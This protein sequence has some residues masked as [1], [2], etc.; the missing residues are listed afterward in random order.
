MPLGS[1]AAFISTVLDP[2]RGEA[3][4]QTEPQAHQQK[5]SD[6]PPSPTQT[7]P[8]AVKR[9]GAMG[10]DNDAGG[11]TAPPAGAPG[12]AG[13]SKVLKLFLL[14]ILCLQ[15]SVYTMHRR[16][17]CVKRCDFPSRWWQR[18]L[19]AG[20]VGTRFN[21]FYESAEDH[22]ILCQRVNV[23]FGRR[24]GAGAARGATPRALFCSQADSQKP[25]LA[26]ILTR[27]QGIG[28]KCA[29]DDSPS[30]A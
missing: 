13:V 27:S 16:Y 25:L 17:R 3:Y 12:N 11:K 19:R 18:Q 20:G 24:W 15:N 8:A 22:M 4:G 21:F 28:K 6:P 9:A 30:P 2:E 5:S 14:V 23:A 1:F 10:N 26:E 7:Q 29:D